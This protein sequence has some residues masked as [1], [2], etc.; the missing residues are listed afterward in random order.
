MEVIV[1]K[2]KDLFVKTFIKW[3][4]YEIYILFGQSV[5]NFCNKSARI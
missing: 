1:Y 3:C 2:K 4:V 5:L